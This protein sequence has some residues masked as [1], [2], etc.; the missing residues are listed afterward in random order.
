MLVV[1]R[2]DP[3]HLTGVRRRDRCSMASTGV[4]PMPAEISS[5][6]VVPGSEH[7]AAPGGSDLDPVAGPQLVMQVGERPSLCDSR[8]TPTA[9]SGRRPDPRTTSS[10]ARRR[11]GASANRRVTN[12]P[13][14]GRRQWDRRRRGG[15]TSRRRLG[16][17]VG[18]RDRRKPA[19]R[20]WCHGRRRRASRAGPPLS[21]MLRKD[22]CQPGLNAGMSRAAS[23][24]CVAPGQV[25]QG[26]DVGDAEAVRAA[27]GADY[28][29]PAAPHPR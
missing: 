2:V 10:C 24:P 18:D 17:G 21:S 8:F 13:G 9:G 11:V 29:S 28:P 7:E 23:S 14:A 15:P 22:C 12:W 16:D 5:T 1:G 27:S 20:V 26:I 3:P 19:T 4:T 25:E 6:G